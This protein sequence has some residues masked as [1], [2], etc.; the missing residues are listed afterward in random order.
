MLLYADDIVFMA[1]S[2][3]ELQQMIHV[4][5]DFCMEYELTVNLAWVVLGKEDVAAKVTYRGQA[6]EQKNKYKYLGILFDCK[7]GPL[8]GVPP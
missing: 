5:S 8:K 2:E 6:I 4:S 3:S 7:L 1:T